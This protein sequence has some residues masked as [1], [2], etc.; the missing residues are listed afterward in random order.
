MFQMK[1]LIIVG[2]GGHAKEVLAIAQSLEI[3]NILLAE[4]NAEVN[5]SVNG[6]SVIP[7]NI[8]EKFKQTSELIIAIGNPKARKEMS[9]RLSSFN[10]KSLIHPTAFIGPQVILGY[11]CLVAPGAILTSNITVGNH[12]LINTNS[13]ISHD[14]VLEDFS[15]ISPNSTVGGNTHIGKGAFISLGATIING[16]TVGEGCLVAAGSV[17]TKSLDK[18]EMVAGVPAQ[19]K[20]HLSDWPSQV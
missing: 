19:I 10:F 12:V 13:V 8:L 2:A 7:M 14:C 5:K 1:Q 4:D 16:I 18:L 17:L 9:Q 3:T 11:G 15:T 20:K 6:V